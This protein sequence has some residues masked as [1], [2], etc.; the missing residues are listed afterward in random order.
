MNKI[1]ECRRIWKRV[2][3]N[4]VAYFTVISHYLPVVIDEAQ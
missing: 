4:I 2:K 1:G 3:E